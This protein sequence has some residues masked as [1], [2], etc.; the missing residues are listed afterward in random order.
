VREIMTFPVAYNA[1][2]SSLA[3]H[4]PPVTS[5]L[6]DQNILL[7]T[8]FSNILALCSSLNVRGQMSNFLYIILDKFI[9]MD[10]TERKTLCRFL[11]QI[12]RN[13]FVLGGESYEMSYN[14]YSLPNIF[15]V[16]GR[17]NI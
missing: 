2:I 10:T 1:G 12:S 14:Y 16:K 3:E 15:M 17:G 4:Q 8:L 6:F 9:R 5:S 11:R 7:N 13:L